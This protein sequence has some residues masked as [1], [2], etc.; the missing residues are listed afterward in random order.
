MWLVNGATLPA[1]GVSA[2]RAD[3]WAGLL[4][5]PISMPPMAAIA[6]MA[7][8]SVLVLDM[9]SPLSCLALSRR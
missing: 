6:P 7:A 9:I 8:V 4:A 5:L 3:A 1:S 2:G